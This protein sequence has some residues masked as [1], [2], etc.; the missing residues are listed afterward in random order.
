[1]KTRIVGKGF[2]Q[3]CTAPPQLWGTERAMMN[4]AKHLCHKAA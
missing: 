1:M 4:V 3:G 2:D